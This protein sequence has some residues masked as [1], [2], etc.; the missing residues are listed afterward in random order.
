M[1][2]ITHILLIVI[3]IGLIS[4]KATCQ[5][6][7]LFLNG[8]EMSGKLLD[9][10]KYE[11]TFK[12]DKEKEFVIDKYRVFSYKQNDT[13]TTV[14]EYDTLSGNFLKVK[15][16]Q[17]FV[18]GERDAYK[19]FKPHFS[20]AIGFAVGGAAGYMMHY[21]NSIAYI[22]V[23]FGYTIT[24]L[25]FPTK[26]NQKRLTDTQYI[27]EDEYLRGYERIARSR[28]TQGALKSSFIGLGVGFLI[29]FIANGS[30]E[31]KK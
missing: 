1:I 3:F 26:V 2:K 14:Y 28:R 5:D 7:I 15:D 10:T 24:S 4:D 22:I 30:S 21:D 12:N 8:K 9:K 19:S 23:P 6:K 17:M 16:M 11:F 31:D 13:E 25:L 20:N 29:S 18:Y 27:K